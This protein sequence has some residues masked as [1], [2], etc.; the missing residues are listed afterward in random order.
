[1][2]FMYFKII[3]NNENIIFMDACVMCIVIFSSKRMIFKF[4]DQR[5]KKIALLS[6]LF[7]SI[8]STMF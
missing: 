4:N 7:L 3:L 6:L 2:F 8:M 1:M 5:V